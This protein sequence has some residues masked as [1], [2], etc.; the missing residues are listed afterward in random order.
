MDFKIALQNNDK[1][2][3]IN[4][5]KNGIDLNKLIDYKYPIFY[6]IQNDNIELIELFFSYGAKINIYSCEC[7]M[8]PIMY[9]I[10]LKKDKIIQLLISYGSNLNFILQDYYTEGI[11]FHSLTLNTNIIFWAYE[12]NPFLSAYI[13]GHI[14][15]VKYILNNQLFDVKKEY[16]SYFNDYE[17]NKNRKK[18]KYMLK[19]SLKIWIPRRHYLIS[20]TKKKYIKLLFNLKYN[21]IFYLPNELW[22][23]ICAFI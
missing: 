10:Q 12:T 23:K 2:K 6:L 17:I 15:A 9:A 18:I 20:N 3:I 22:F 11:D 4:Y 13:Y 5:V 1:Y 14:K 19:E 7:S 16:F 21:N 8:T